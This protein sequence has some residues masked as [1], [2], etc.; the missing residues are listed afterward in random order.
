V[1]NQR[2]FKEEFVDRFR[3]LFVLALIFVL[4][5]LS[6]VQDAAW[7][8]SQATTGVI[9]GVAVDESGAAIPGVAVTLINTATNYEQTL[10]TDASGRFR[11]LALP[12]GPYEVTASLEGFATLVRDGIQLSVGRTVS[13]N[14]NMK[15]STVGDEILVTDTAPLIETART[16][17]S[18]LIDRETLDGIPNNGRD[19][20]EFTKLT[21]G[22]SI[23]QGPDGD[24]LTINGQK[25]IQNNISVDGADFNNPFFGEQRGGQRPAFTFN[26]DAIAEFVVVPDGAPAEFGRSSGGFVNVVTKSGTNNTSG[27]ANLFFKNDSL[28]TEAE[29]QDGTTEPESDFD[30]TQIG[31]T[32]GGPIKE[33]KLFYFLAADVQTGERTSQNDPTRIEQRVVDA[34][35]RFGSTNENAPITRTDDATVALAK[36]DWTLANNQ[37]FTLRYSFIDSEQANGTF[38]VDSWGVSAN[39]VE[40]AE[41]NSGSGSLISTFGGD[42]LNELRF[43][44]AREDRPRPYGGPINPNTGRPLPDTA[45][46]FVNGYRF[47]MP[48]FIPVDYHDTRVQ[49][50]NNLSWLRGAHTFKG[51]LEYNQT[52]AS[53]V[54]RGFVNGRVIFGSTEGFLNFIDNP[55]YVECS[56]G[57]SSQ[58]GACPA[59]T[60]PVGPVL[61]YLQQAG[62]GGLTG[63]Q[64]GAQTIE[65]DEPAIFFQD[66]WQPRPNLTVQYG[67]RWEA[68][69][70]PDTITPASEVFFAPFIGQTVTTA[71][72]PQRFPSNGEIP[73]DDAMW[74]PRLGISWD[75]NGDGR[76]VVRANAGVFNARIPGLALASTRSTNGSVGQS[77][78]RSSATPFLG[79]VPAFGELIP[80]SEIGDPF[81]PDV[82]VFDEDFENPETTTFSLSYEREFMPGTS[83]L[84]KYNYAKGENLTRFTNRNDPLLGSPW[85]TGLAPAGINGVNTLTVV[86]STAESEYNGYTLGLTRQDPKYMVQAYYTYSEDMSDDDNERDPFS[87]RYAKI[88]DLDAEFGYSD[89]HQPNRFNLWMLWHLPRE[90]DLNVRYSYRSAQ[91]QSI[92]AS[93]DIAAT[94]QDRINPDGSVT[95]RNLGRRDNQFSS[96]DVRLSRTWDVGDYS[97]E[98]IV[99]AFNLLNESN[100]LTPEVTNL[101]FNFDGTVTS[102][103]GDPRQFQVGVRVRWK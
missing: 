96:L 35:A 89:R 102:G 70:Q 3:S 21:P 19:F 88:T 92:T 63:E 69:L 58:T 31:F 8:Q 103:V 57:S 14:L 38:D 93:G 52:R 59:G 7:A 68:Q 87:F 61:L 45:F 23:V 40:Q 98:A 73:D 44:Y 17:S 33:N 56:D 9:E 41:S 77:L 26:I 6:V 37:L 29:R 60:S 32:L 16:E 80:Q 85:S 4:A 51:G 42:L 46:D 48:F 74:Q 62:V 34:L 49:V 22:V 90:L 47:G 64:A 36:L 76:S 79:P 67:L 20:L 82:F 11:G 54:F 97:I 18:V 78:F 66:T 53:Q 65:Q 101:I 72:G 83:Y 25:G 95:Q 28:S 15:L 84:V 30:Q 94:P 75:P 55:N 24:E 27:T 86:E 39:A 1:T 12:L 5:P 71:A 13:L 99:D 10:V 50:N 91:P 100:F 2:N 43:Q 81:L